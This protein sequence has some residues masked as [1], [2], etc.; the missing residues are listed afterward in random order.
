MNFSRSHVC[1]KHMHMHAHKHVN[2]HVMHV[3]MPTS[4]LR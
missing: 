2:K 3:S 4:N 1:S